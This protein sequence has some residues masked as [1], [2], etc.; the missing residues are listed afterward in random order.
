[1]LASILIIALSLG[2]L[3]YW[4]RYSCILLLRNLQDLPELSPALEDNR[5][6]VGEVQQLLKTAETLDPLHASLQRDYQVLTYLLEHAA[7]LELQAFEDR[8]LVIDYRVMQWW[9]RLT[10]TAAPEQAR[11]ALKEMAEVLAVLVCKIDQRA[12][13]RTEA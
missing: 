7:G 8:L 10:R 4:F 1:M 5:F 9:Y 11:Q 13:V 2:M 6:H 12:A 3:V